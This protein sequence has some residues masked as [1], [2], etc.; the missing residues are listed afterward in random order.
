MHMRKS[1]PQLT[2]SHRRSS[3]LLLCHSSIG[4]KNNIRH[5]SWNKECHD[6]TAFSNAAC[7]AS[8]QM[9]SGPGQRQELI[10]ATFATLVVTSMPILKFSFFEASVNFQLWVA[11]EEFSHIMLRDVSLEVF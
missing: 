2:H 7:T 10:S 8:V 9:G 6:H 5:T 11:V 3:S 1:E 4:S